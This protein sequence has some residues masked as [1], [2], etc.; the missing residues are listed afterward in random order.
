MLVPNQIKTILQLRLTEVQIKGVNII[1]R[2]H[3]MLLV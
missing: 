3:D 2:I 1:Q